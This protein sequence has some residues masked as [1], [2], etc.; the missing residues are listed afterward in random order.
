VLGFF[1]ISLVNCL[2]GAGFELPSFLIFASGVGRIT[3]VS[4]WR[5]AQDILN[6]KKKK[7]KK[8]VRHPWK[9]KNKPMKVKVG[10][11]QSV[12]WNLFAELAG[13]ALIQTR[14]CLRQHC[15]H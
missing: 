2:P 10:K 9:S 12:D 8:G 15:K 4:H 3:G 14:C 11:R 5:L 7:K 1:K 6:L 13:L